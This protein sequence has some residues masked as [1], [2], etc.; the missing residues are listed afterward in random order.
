MPVSTRKER[1]YKYLSSAKW[2]KLR[3]RVLAR[4]G[5]A[6]TE[7]C[8]PDSLQ[9]HHLTYDRVFE[10]EL[11]DLVTLCDTCHGK[12]HE[13][14]KKRRRQHNRKRN[15]LRYKGKNGMRVYRNP[16]IV[17][18]AGGERYIPA[19]KKNKKLADLND[20]LHVRQLQTKAKLEAAKRL[21]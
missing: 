12:Q 17:S 10:E 8:S 13:K 14:T 2:R 1:Y 9:V 3:E 21:A 15:R 7:C 16:R 19:R 11:D 4:D 6:C 5:Y 20:E 18:G